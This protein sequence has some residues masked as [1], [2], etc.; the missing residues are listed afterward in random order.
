MAIC[1]MFMI[2]GTIAIVPYRAL[3]IIDNRIMALWIISGCP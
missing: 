1:P 2:G 3:W